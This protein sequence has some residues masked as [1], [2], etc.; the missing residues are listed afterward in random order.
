VCSDTHVPE[1]DFAVLRGTLDDYDD[2]PSASDAFSVVEVADASY[3]RDA[4]EKLAGYARAGV[5]QYVILDLRHRRAEVH[6]EPSQATG[7]YASRQSVEA[8]QALEL[9]VGEA[10]FLPVPLMAILP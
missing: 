9:R 8:G 7:T 3:D 2:L 5:Q 4:G 10:E 6:T 1:P